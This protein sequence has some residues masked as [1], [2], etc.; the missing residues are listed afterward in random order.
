MICSPKQQIRI[1]SARLTG[2]I[3]SLQSLFKH[4]PKIFIF[5]GTQLDPESTFHEVDVHNGDTILALPLSLQTNQM[6]KEQWISLTKD[7]DEFSEK[8]RWI[9]NPKTAPEASRL[10]DIHMDRIERRPRVFRKLCQ[11]YLSQDTGPSELP[12]LQEECSESPSAPS[13]EALPVF[14]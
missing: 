14:W 1:I 9:V 13:T 2:K 4:M 5:N 7:S 8:M 11:L 3:K 6:L 12:K 10:K